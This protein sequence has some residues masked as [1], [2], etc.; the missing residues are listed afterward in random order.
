M[1]AARRAML[2]EALQ[3]IDVPVTVWVQGDEGAR[4]AADLVTLQELQP[5]LAVRPVHPVLPHPWLPIERYP[6]YRVGM[7]ESP[8]TAR[9]GFVG[10][11][12]GFMLDAFCDLAVAVS[13]G[14]APASP[15][16]RDT[17]RQMRDPVAI[18]IL[19]SPG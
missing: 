13:R 17:L 5:L 6:V 11:P 4:E 1:L 14:D 18:T 10:F 16:A 3:E 7:P 2:G 12:E 8:Q 9:A 19:T 15:L